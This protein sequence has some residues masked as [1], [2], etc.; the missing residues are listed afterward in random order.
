[1]PD[2]ILLVDDEQSVLSSLRRSLLEEPYDILTA[3]SGTEGL[4]IL[5]IRKSGNIPVMIYA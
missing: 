1:M 5:N 2:N 3:N 4:D